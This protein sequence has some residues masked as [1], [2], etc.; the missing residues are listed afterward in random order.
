MRGGER[1]SFLRKVFAFR[2]MWKIYFVFLTDSF[3]FKAIIFMS[4]EIWK[5]VFLTRCRK[6]KRVLL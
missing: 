4:F 5:I 2:E 1:I 3:R 6:E